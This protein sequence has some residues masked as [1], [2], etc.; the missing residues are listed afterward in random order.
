MA[1]KLGCH[2]T[3]NTQG[4]SNGIAQG[5]WSENATLIGELKAGDYIVEYDYFRTRSD[6]A[7]ACYSYEIGTKDESGNRIVLQEGSYDPVPTGYANV[8]SDTKELVTLPNDGTYYK[9]ARIRNDG[10]ENLDA[11]VRIDTLQA[12]GFANPATG[13]QGPTGPQ[14]A[15]G[16][17]GG[18]GHGLAGDD[19]TRPKNISAVWVMRI[20]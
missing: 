4:L 10:G 19:E 20:K 2:V 9:Y 1:A 3:A 14:G 15:T 13:A 6:I 12:I 16:A 7:G 18:H 8:D 5:V 17:G 11:A